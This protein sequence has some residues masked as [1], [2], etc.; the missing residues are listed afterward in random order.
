MN[1][2][3]DYFGIGISNLITN[4]HQLTFKGDY[5]QTLTLERTGTHFYIENYQMRC[6]K[7]RSSRALKYTNFKSFN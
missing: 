3:D 2:L 4:Q 5:L 6:D 1:A 7:A